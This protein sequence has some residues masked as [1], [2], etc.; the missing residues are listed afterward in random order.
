M[1]M[2]T[3]IIIDRHQNIKL[4][5]FYGI[6]AALS[7]AIMSVFVKKIGNTLSTSQLLFFR[8][9]ISFLLLLFW[10]VNNIHFTLRAHQPIRYVIA[11]FVALLALTC[12]FSA[13]KYLPL[14]DALLLNNTAPLFVPLFAW[15]MISSKTSKKPLI[16]IVLGFIGVAI[17]LH[18]GKEIFSFV[19]LI[20]LLSGILAALS[21]VQMRL[22]SK[23]SSTQQILF[24][25]LLIN[26]IVS[27]SVALFQWQ[28]PQSIT[29]WLFLLGIGIFGA[30][31]QVFSTLSYVTALARIVSPM[32]FLVVIFGSFFDWLLWNNIPNLL[33]IL[34]GVFI[35]GGAIITI[36]FGQKKI[37]SPGQNE[38]TEIK[39]C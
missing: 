3:T 33:T 4:G 6:I 19:S 21:I 15:M 39:L 12:V 23:T 30:L 13:I 26:S 22:I 27:G 14:V 37:I 5:V 38:V 34:G 31:N 18:P 2:M 32:M 25:Y 24:Y 20:A 35:I 29:A 11:I 7:F 16:G 17:I 9:G 10:V 1:S 8:F 36:Y 28:S